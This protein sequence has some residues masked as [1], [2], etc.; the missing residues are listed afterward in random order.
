MHLPV[1]LRDKFKEFPPCPEKLTPKMEWFSEF[2]KELGTK[3][4]TIRNDKYCGS[5][6]LVPHLCNHKYCIHY[7]HLKFIHEVGVKH[8]KLHP[9]FS[10]M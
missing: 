7:K 8:N 6:K 2:Q 5:D 10:F 9:V 1:E 4:G 3:S